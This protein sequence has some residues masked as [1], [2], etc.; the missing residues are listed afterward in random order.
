LTSAVANADRIESLLQKDP[1]KI[2]ED[3]SRRFLEIAGP[4]DRQLVLFGAGQLGR[5]TLK[6]LRKAGIEPLA[7]ADNNTTIHGSQVEGVPVISPEE[8]ARRWSPRATFVV[9]VYNVSAPFSQLRRC[10]VE[11]IASY[12]DLFAAHRDYLLPFMCL[13]PSA[14]VLAHAGNIRAAYALMADEKS[15][16]EF[17]RQ[18][19]R[20]LFI[21][22]D[23]PHP[24]SEGEH[25]HEYFP[26]EVYAPLN[27]EVFV[28]CGAYD[29]DTLRRFLQFRGDRWAKIIALEPD[30]ASF[31]RLGAFVKGLPASQSQ[32]IR[33]ERVAVSDRRGLLAFD[34]SGS[35]V[36]SA[37]AD[38][39]LRVEAET[40]DSLLSYENPTLIKMDLEGAEPEALRGARATLQRSR[41]VLAV[42]VYHR[43]AHL[44]DLPILIRE[45][46]PEQTLAL[47]AHSEDCWDASLYAISPGRVVAQTERRA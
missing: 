5:I 33:I 45:M 11:R 16:K 42:C 32:K 35:V 3:A 19:E 41:P 47:R 34:A 29:G 1:A 13:G 46:A 20:R 37:R 17:I 44:W 23:E 28:D 12:A 27:D 2:D 15:R 43:P 38:G 6:G 30:P 10:V 24:L 25:E 26:E 8:A 14:G 4:F 18:L 31:K 40:L 21:G 36:S 22:F 9:T 39:H 7:F